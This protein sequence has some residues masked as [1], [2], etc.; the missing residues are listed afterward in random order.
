[1]VAPETTFDNQ[2]VAFSANIQIVHS[3]VLQSYW[4]VMLADEKMGGIGINSYGEFN[5]VMQDGTDTYD[6]DFHFD[7]LR[8]AS[9]WA[10]RYLISEE[11]EKGW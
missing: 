11:I 3:E 7:S 2:A 8:K 9:A 4:D 10:M 6:D 1:M 5:V